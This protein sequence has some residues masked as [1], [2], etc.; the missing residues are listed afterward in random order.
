VRSRRIHTVALSST[1]LVF[2]VGC[3][4][5]VMRARM[6]VPRKTTQ[7]VVHDMRTTPEVA[8]LVEELSREATRGAVAG[9]G[10][11]ETAERVRSFVADI[12]RGMLDEMAAGARGPAGREI[13]ADLTSSVARS[14]ADEL[15]RS[16]G[17]AMRETIV[18]ELLRR[19]DFRQALNETSR[20]I[21]KHVALGTAEAVTQPAKKEK[22]RGL[23]PT[24]ADFLPSGLWLVPPLV[25]LLVLGIPVALLLKQ[26]RASRQY[27][28]QTER[29]TAIATALLNAA[30][31]DRDD[32]ALRSLLARISASL[33]AEEAAGGTETPP[34][35]PPRGTLRPA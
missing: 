5:P 18:Q 4:P 10:D 17:P 22:L 2:A 19:P 30:Q 21:G 6:E 20:D 24:L 9:L 26:R 12:A 34:A 14:F 32:P 25:L 27:R 33:T 23:F 13:T 3:E 8:R 15:P 16:V 29:R 35:E 28:E 11:A 31:A 1:L 7:G